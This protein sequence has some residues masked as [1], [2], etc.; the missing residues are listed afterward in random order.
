VL[1]WTT[2]VAFGLFR[3]VGAL[4]VPLTMWL[5]RRFSG[6]VGAGAMA[7]LVVALEPIPVRLSAS[8][9]E[10][11]IAA[12]CAVAAWAWWQL[13]ASDA[14]LTPRLLAVLWAWL[15]VL[16]RAD[17]LPQLLL[18]PVFTVVGQPLREGT[19]WLPIRRRLADAASFVVALAAI[20]LHAWVSIVVP[21]NHPRPDPE[22]IVRTARVILTQ[23]WVIASEPPH[24]LT[25]PCLSIAAMGC[26]ALVLLRRP[27]L[28]GAVGL[29][30]V[31]IFVPLGRNL[32][33][34]GLTGARYF[35]LLM[36]VLGLLAAALAELVSVW[37]PP[38]QRRTTASA[39]LLGF[40]ALELSAAQSGWRHEYTFQA[41]YRFLGSALRSYR[42]AL[43]ACTLWFVRPRQPTGELDLDCCLWPAASPL[44]LLAPRVRFRPIPADH[45]PADADGCHLYYEGS[46]CSL[47][48]RDEAAASV[49]RLVRQCEVLRA[50][51]GETLTELQVTDET[52]N[53]RFRNRPWVRLRA[54]GL[55]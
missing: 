16:T 37:F 14:R 32:S 44:T 19:P 39:A 26:I 9:S 25:W 45:E 17:C 28:L 38:M 23:F 42:T 50:R 33:H 2:E 15:A 11:V 10:H 22:G 34:D 31:L 21:S 30:C 1:P 13:G 46:V 47:E 35:V 4:A 3:V 29:A 5:V 7:G 48:P 12:S 55:R 43:D 53:Q 41:E 51:P 52:L 18:L 54:R 36:P 8:S 27:R 49:P 6:S 40:G 20:G 24:W